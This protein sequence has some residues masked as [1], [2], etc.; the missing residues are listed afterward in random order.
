MAIYCA[1]E[2]VAS[3]GL[4]LDAVGRHNVGVYVGTTEHGN[5]ETENMIQEALARLTEGR[6]SV[7][8]AHR[9]STIREADQILVL[10][11]GQIIERGRHEELL[12]RGG[13]YARLYELHMSD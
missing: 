6:T 9:L 3:A 5:V 4:D 8:I 11:H 7:V 13:E 2:A 12:E 1:N 10:R